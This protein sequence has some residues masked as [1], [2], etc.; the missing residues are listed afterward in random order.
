[1]PVDSIHEI[2]LYNL[3][4]GFFLSDYTHIALSTPVQEAHLHYFK[5]KYNLVENEELK[6][7][8]LVFADLNGTGKSSY[9]R[10]LGISPDELVITYAITTKS[11]GTERYYFL[12]TMDE[13]FSSLSDIINILDENIRLLI[14]IHP[15]FYLTNDEIK[16][17]L[18][19]SSRYIIH[20]EGPFS[21]ALAASDILISYSSTAIDEALINGIPVLLYDKWNRYN[22][23]TTGVYTNPQSPDIFPVCYVNDRH[24]LNE[25]LR[26]MI[27][28]IGVAQKKDIATDKY[29]Y[30]A[31]YSDNLH[32]FINE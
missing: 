20:R 10:K 3:C 5:Q 25:A 26:Y 32:A 31:D 27:D 12:E 1:V 8:P 18:P 28:K 15:G 16:I 4:K 24:K 2:E 29:C 21:E 14:R 9:K 19:E 7:G 11:R 30:N 6:T 23:F 22:H 13:F 17:L